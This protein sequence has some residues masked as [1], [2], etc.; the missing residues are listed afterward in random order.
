[1]ISLVLVL[2]L[3]GC[4]VVGDYVDIARPRD[5]SPE[6]R[7]A[8][9]EWTRD[10]TVYSEFSTRAKMAATF[11]SR[12][13]VDAY[14]AEYA[15]LYRQDEQ[16]L[17]AVRPAAEHAGDTAEFL[18]YAYVP[19]REAIDLDQPESVWRVF[20]VTPG[21][22]RLNPRDIQEL[23]DAGPGITEFYP[24]VNPA[25]GKIYLLTFDAA[26][27]REGGTELPVT[28]VVTGV[29]ARVELQWN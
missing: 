20:L 23:R 10:T 26:P 24:Y 14:L 2:V 22:D 21:G 15:R 6:Y 9:Q 17:P 5:F 19:D 7:A 29:I 3:A 16:D 18:L 13:F 28:L 8:L 1:M 4:A 11:R 25:Y 27:L 12:T